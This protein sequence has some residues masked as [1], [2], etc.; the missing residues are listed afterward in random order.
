[1]KWEGASID[2]VWL[3][4]VADLLAS[5]H[6][7]SPRGQ[8]TR[9]YLAAQ[10]QFDAQLPLLSVPARRL[11]Y[12]FAAAEAL[13]MILGRRDVAPLARV[14]PKMSQFSDDGATLAGAYGPRFREQLGYALGCL[15][16][17]DDTRQAVVE[18]WRPSPA[19]SRDVPCTLSWQFLNR[20]G[21]LHLIATMRS[22]DAWLGVPYDAFSFACVLQFV[23]G[24]AGL[25]PGRVVMNLGSSHLYARD[26]KDASAVPPVRDSRLPGP[27]Q[28]WLEPLSG[29]ASPVLLVLE[30]VLEDGEMDEAQ[31]ELLE[32]VPGWHALARAVC[33]RTS[34]EA[35]EVLRGAA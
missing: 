19:P 3:A 21:A 34:A 18:I 24:L 15:A 35:L 16:S 30:R 2:T 25:G 4:L 23:A 10:L 11:N 29:V 33:A 14:N 22:S 27:P 5:Q 31:H 17:D 13:W 9:E 32:T 1:M 20:G 6:E 12:R 8:L 7:A 26:F 28:L